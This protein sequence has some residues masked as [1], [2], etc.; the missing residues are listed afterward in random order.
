MTL[1]ILSIGIG[2]LELNLQNI[3]DELHDA[4]LA[5]AHWKDLG[6]KLGMKPHVLEDIRS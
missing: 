3:P 1:A 6:L 5:A 4:G 2:S